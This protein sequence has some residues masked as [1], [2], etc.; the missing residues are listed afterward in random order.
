MLKFLSAAILT[1]FIGTQIGMMFEYTKLVSESP[2][3]KIAAVV[4]ADLPTVAGLTENLNREALA[5]KLRA[6]ADRLEFRQRREARYFFHNVEQNVFA[7]KIYAELLVVDRAGA[8]LEEFVAEWGTGAA[9]RRVVLS[10]QEKELLGSALRGERTARRDEET[11]TNALAFPLRARGGSIAGALFLREAV[12]FTWW[13]AFTKSFYDFLKDLRDFWVAVAV[14]GFI[15]GFL[16]AH[17]IAHRLDRIA[18]AVQSWSKGDFS[19]RASEKHFDELGGLARL[20]N[21]MAKSLQEVFRIKQELAMSEERNRIARDLHDSVKQQVFGLAL[22]IGAA[23]AMLRTNPDGVAL[24]LEEAESLVGQVQ[25]ELVDL[26]RELR[27]Q[28]EEKL[29]E[30]LKIYVADWARQTG[31]TAKLSFEKT[32]SLAPDAENTL[33]RIVQESLSNVARHSRAGEVA[34]RLE[35]QMDGFRLSVVD[36]GG[37]FAPERAKTGFGLQTMRERAETL[38]NGALAVESAPGRGTTVGVDF[39]G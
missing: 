10:D 23:K 18:V 2:P 34:I 36:D 15:F 39:D 16:Q 29:E 37:G 9:G 22:Q 5:L 26:I 28:R 38:K 17:Q 11:H 25:G 33:F 32:V 14:C 13:E 27:P 12:P 1:W 8:P 6:L 31:I 24:R 4:E 20:L 19:A 30:K 3:E 7:G 35:R 21:R